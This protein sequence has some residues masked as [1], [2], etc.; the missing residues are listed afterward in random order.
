MFTTPPQMPVP[1]QDPTASS[2]VYIGDFG[3]NAASVIQVKRKNDKVSVY[4]VG[5]SWKTFKGDEGQAVWK[6]FT[7]T[8]TQIVPP[9]R[10]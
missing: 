10:L 7:S 8:A 2:L 5:G 1:I 3:F 4:F 9:R 6:W